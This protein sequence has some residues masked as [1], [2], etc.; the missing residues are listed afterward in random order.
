MFD[1]AL[2]GRGR[3]IGELHNG[4]EKHATGWLALKCRPTKFRSVGYYEAV[5]REASLIWDAI[6]VPAMPC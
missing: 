6:Y 4:L 5:V 1:D 2:K 3:D